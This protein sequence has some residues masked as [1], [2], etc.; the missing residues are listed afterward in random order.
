[1]PENN[2]LNSGL[3]RLRSAAEDKLRQLEAAPAEFTPD[4][5]P[6]LLE[7]LSIHQVELEM[8]NDELRETQYKLEASYRNFSE[9]YHHAPVAYLRLDLQGI[10]Q[11]CNQKFLTWTQG[12]RKRVEGHKVEQ[13]VAAV[14]R[15]YFRHWLAQTARDHQSCCIRLHCTQEMQVQA[16]V[17]ELTWGQETP[18]LLLVLTDITRLKQVEQQ[19]ELSSTLF[20]AAS[21]GCI[22]TDA[23][24]KILVVNQ[25]LCDMTG[26]QSHELQ[27]KTPAILRSGRHDSQ[28]YREFWYQLNSS[29]EWRGEIWNRHKNGQVLPFR[30]V[31]N[32][33]YDIQGKPLRYVALY[34]DISKQ[35]QQEAL[36]YHQ[37][38]H[39]VL[40][41][42]V[43][44]S[45]FQDHLTR[46][47]S[48]C[49]RSQKQLALMMVDL[50]G[51]KEVNDMFGHQQGDQVLI[52][53]A[54]RLLS[55]VRN[56]DVVARFGG[57]EFCIILETSRDARKYLDEIARKIIYCLEQPV[58][59]GGGESAIVTASIG[60]SIY[61]DDAQSRDMLM[62]SADQAMYTIKH[63]GKNGIC[64]FRPQIQQDA[65]QRHQLLQELRQALVAKQFELVYQPIVNMHSGK[66][67]KAEALIRWLHPEKGMIHPEH[68]ISQA[69]DSGLI[70]PM[71]AWVFHQVT[72][73]V[74]RW[75]PM[76][77]ELSISLNVS[78]LQLSHNRDSFWQLV[79]DATDS[80]FPSGTITVEI[81]ESAL[82]DNVEHVD[83]HLISLRSR[84]IRLALDDFGTGFSSLSYL[85]NFHVDFLKIDQSFIRGLGCNP[86]SYTLCETMV[87]MAHKLGIEVIAEGIETDTQRDLLKQIG[88]DYGQGFLYSR[89]LAANQFEDLLTLA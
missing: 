20:N 49:R 33:Q 34:S 5:I 72:Q 44:R 15:P 26:Y 1:M 56:S 70:L 39:D 23:E 88:C 13:F 84:Q 80:C 29:G 36:I 14:D 38:S 61:P 55:C 35:K 75:H 79:D 73:D 41:G 16:A 11:Q 17:H 87:M 62:R 58:D 3:L 64:Y 85:Q 63:S 82:L 68:F 43:N 71:G 19:L 18:S 31:V 25:A 54:Q 28:F 65:W 8:Q 7:E 76:A 53:T 12:Q 83:K 37:A 48:H 89:P 45:C 67:I 47:L 21:E 9:L 81:T 2:K 24:H 27:G 32:I 59:I 30:A 77:P 42:L 74:T 57:D 78:A 86:E 52:T 40:T 60:I 66:I 50:D 22:V 46:M 4:D 69:E 51:F 6:A 10:I